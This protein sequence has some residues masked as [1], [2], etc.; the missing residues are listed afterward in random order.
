MVL[1]SLGSDVP[2]FTL[3]GR[4]AGFGRG[5]EVYKM[6]D[7]G[8]SWL[9]LVDPGVTIP[10]AEAYSWLTVSNKLNSIEGFCAPYGPECAT[11]QWTNDFEAPVFS[12]YP[13]LAT[14]KDQLLKFGADRAALSGSGSAVYGEFQ[15][16]S[17]A[18]R[19]G[20]ALDGRFRVK[21]TKPLPRWEYFQR[22]VEEE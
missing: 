6:D 13:E 14:I 3:G 8:A 1:R 11:N 15:M 20:S 19:A 10:T 2:F 21:L 7:A 5:D 4:A 12:R 17:D 22:M 18:I 9:V 16:I